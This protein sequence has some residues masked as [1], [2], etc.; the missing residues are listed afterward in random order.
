MRL[1]DT[2]QPARP[3]DKS[4]IKASRAAQVEIGIA[5]HAQFG[6]NGSA[7]PAGSVEIDTEPVAG[8]GRAVADV[9]VSVGQRFESG[10]HLFSKR[11]L[12]AVAG[13]VQPPDLSRRLCGGQRMQH[14]KHRRRAD[15]GTQK[16]DRSVT[17]PQRK[18][19][20]RGGQSR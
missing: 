7:E 20:A 13:T 18:A 17:R 5:R 19:A 16:N 6:E 14:G 12:P 1:L 8:T 2:P 15:A 9:T 4:A 10:P 11:V 3:A